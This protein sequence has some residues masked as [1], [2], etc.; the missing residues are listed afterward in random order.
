MEDNIS[1]ALLMAAAMLIFIIAITVTFSLI[2]QTKTTSDIILYSY[3]DTKYYDQGY[4]D[5]TYTL[6]NEKKFNRI[7]NIETIMPTVYRYIKENYGVT[8][9]DKKGKILARFD[10]T[11]ESVVN[12]WKNYLDIRNTASPEYKT[13]STFYKDLTENLK[14]VDIYETDGSGNIRTRTIHLKW[15]EIDTYSGDFAY[16]NLTPL[17][18]RI[19]KQEGGAANIQYG[20]PFAGIPLQIAKRLDFDFGGNTNGYIDFN[21][22]YTKY[23][24]LKELDGKGLL[25]FY[26][27]KNFQEVFVFVSDDEGV[28][29]DDETGDSVITKANTTKL[30]IIYVMM[31]D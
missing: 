2:S 26:S 23:Y 29:T 24:G 10:S 27:N 11:T 6:A 3:D 22:S 1:N 9:I 19:Y 21:N 18:E 12:K 14:S 13:V 25:N 15:N 20:A 8:I 30:E 4:E 31:E 16:K 17:W 7:V 28:V 5:I